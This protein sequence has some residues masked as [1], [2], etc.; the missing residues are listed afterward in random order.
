M[1]SDSHEGDGY[2]SEPKLNLSL[3]HCNIR[4]VRILSEILIRL[5]NLALILIQSSQFHASNIWITLLK[6]KQ[7]FIQYSF[8]KRTNDLL[9]RF[10]YTIIYIT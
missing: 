1:Y 8:I 9:H 4:G 5:C 10:L 2:L 7:Q 6:K 3:K